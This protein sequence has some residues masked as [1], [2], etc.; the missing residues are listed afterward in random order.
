MKSAIR[1]VG[2]IGAL[3]GLVV[4]FAM[5]WHTLQHWRPGPWHRVPW[6]FIILL[7]LM[8]ALAGSGS[9]LAYAWRDTAFVIFS[10]SAFMGLQLAYVWFA[11]VFFD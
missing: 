11:V 7:V 10:V 3:A 8:L 4:I 5:T 2:A 6:F 9:T 1:F